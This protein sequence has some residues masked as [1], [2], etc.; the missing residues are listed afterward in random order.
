MDGRDTSPT[1]GQHY[2]QTLQDDIAAKGSGQIA[3]VIGRYFAMD[4]DNRWER[5]QQAYE[6]MT[7]AKGEVFSDP[8]TAL[9]QWY[10]KD[11]TDEFI[12]ASIIR[13]EG[14]DANDRSSISAPTAPAKSPAPSWTKISRH[15]TG[16]RNWISTTSA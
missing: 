10:E 15:S 13:P 7:Q 1:N 5:V 6:A 16:A 2:L 9:K 4:R 14:T 3:T 8:V 11:K 12:P